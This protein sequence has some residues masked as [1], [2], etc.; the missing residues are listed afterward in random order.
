MNLIHFKSISIISRRD[1]KGFN[2]EF[3]PKVNIIFGE[4]DTGKSSLI[5]SLYFTLGGDCRIDKDWKDDDVITKVC[6]SVKGKLYS[7]IRH[8]K[9][10]SIFSNSEDTKPIVT[11]SHMSA[12]AK[13]VRD[14]FDFNLQ[15]SYKKNRQT[16]SGQPCLFIFTFLY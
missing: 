16:N 6:I 4:N 5:K 13:K 3:S 9:R 14:I 10:I 12:I 11:S 1:K 8:N 7:F 15:L 2:F